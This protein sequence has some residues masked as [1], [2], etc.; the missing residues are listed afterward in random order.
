LTLLL[1]LLLVL[2]PPIAARGG[3]A[4]LARPTFAVSVF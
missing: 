2:P 4:V 1:L 3:L